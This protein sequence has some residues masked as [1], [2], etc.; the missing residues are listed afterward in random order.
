MKRPPNKDKKWY[1]LTK[2]DSPPQPSTSDDPTT[3]SMVDNNME[4]ETFWTKKR[5]SSR[6]PGA[7]LSKTKGTQKR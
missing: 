3:T 1:Y 5:L 4:M 7:E 2:F 6:N